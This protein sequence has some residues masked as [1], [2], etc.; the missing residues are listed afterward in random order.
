MLAIKTH[1]TLA[2]AK[3]MAVVILIGV[4]QVQV[5][6]MSIKAQVELLLVMSN[7]I[8]L[9]WRPVMNWY[10]HSEIKMYDYIK[11]RERQ[12]RQQLFED[13]KY[14]HFGDHT[15]YQGGWG[16]ESMIWSVNQEQ[17][18]VWCTEARQE[19]ITQ[20]VRDTIFNCAPGN[21]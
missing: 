12:S 17:G 1:K 18:F 21:D 7:K 4:E 13:I 5:K 20:W 6:S 11:I 16:P 2:N 8:E 15:F 14:S 10:E 9:E 19:E 3:T